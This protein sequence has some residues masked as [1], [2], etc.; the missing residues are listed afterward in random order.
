MFLI[1]KQIFLNSYIELTLFYLHFGSECSLQL[2]PTAPFPFFNNPNLHVN[3]FVQ[4]LAVRYDADTP[5]ALSGNLK[6]GIS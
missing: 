3:P 4:F 2:N 5:P 1:Y 6:P